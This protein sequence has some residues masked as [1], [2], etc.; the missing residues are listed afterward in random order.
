MNLSVEDGYFKVSLSER[1]LLGLLEQW[2][3]DRA[4]FI[5]RTT[6][7]GVVHL[8]VEDDSTHYHSAM[9][10]KEVRGEAGWSGLTPEIVRIPAPDQQDTVELPAVA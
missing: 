4:A 9:R 3:E 2:R 5:G 8:V 6:Q 1:N 10:E 7:H